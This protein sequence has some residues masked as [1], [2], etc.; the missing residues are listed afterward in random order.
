MMLQA[1]DPRC[2][3]GGVDGVHL[4]RPARQRGTPDFSP[5]HVCE[6]NGFLL[7]M[8]RF[9]LSVPPPGSPNRLWETLRKFTGSFVL[10][11]QE[12]GQSL[13]PMKIRVRAQCRGK[14]LNSG[15]TATF[16][17]FVVSKNAHS[18]QALHVMV[19]I[20]ELHVHVQASALAR[21]AGCLV[22]LVTPAS[23]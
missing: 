14:R 5:E 9:G 21:P 3:H 22:S 6:C 20:R 13:A 19:L 17:R 11:D 15:P 2:D 4:V 8:V 23:R 1:V 7:N 12:D 16:H 10:V 18:A